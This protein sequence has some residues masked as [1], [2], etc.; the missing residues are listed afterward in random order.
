MATY[1]LPPPLYPQLASFGLEKSG[2]QFR[3]PFNGTV[4]ALDFNAERWKVSLTTVPVSTEA[5]GALEG[6]ANLMAG[7]MN[8]L[9]LGHPTRRVPVGS[10][11][12][13]PV[14][15]AA[16]VRGDRLLTLAN[17]TASDN[18]MATLRAG[19]LIGDDAGTH[20]WQ[21]ASDCQAAPDGT[22][23]VPLI[24]RVRQTLQAGTGIVWNRPRVSFIAP[25][26][27]HWVV[28]QPGY[29][30]GLPLDLEERWD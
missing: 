19:D 23:Q 29:A 28:H 5:A 22:L 30:E 20:L 14:L 3:S 17:L 1:D 9:R 21:V 12:G 26:L 24:N 7:G 11:R 10:L 25:A 4:Q 18:G 8:R 13:A 16:A 2:L 27:I 6:L 15:A